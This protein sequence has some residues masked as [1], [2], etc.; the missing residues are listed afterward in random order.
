MSSLQMILFLG[1]ALFIALV[2]SYAIRKKPKWY[3]GSDQEN[4]RLRPEDRALIFLFIFF[5]AYV[6]ISLYDNLSFHGLSSSPQPFSHT[7]LK[8]ED[9][10]EINL[11]KEKKLDYISDKAKPIEVKKTFYRGER[12][13][14]NNNLDY[15]SLDPSDIDD[16]L[17]SIPGFSSVKPK[18]LS[19]VDILKRY[20]AD[21]KSNTIVPKG[22]LL[23]GQ[24]GNGAEELALAIGKEW[25][26]KVLVFDAVD[27]NGFD[28]GRLRIS[29]LFSTSTRYSPVVIIIKNIDY[30]L[31]AGHFAD[32]L[33]LQPKERM[34][35]WFD[36]IYQS[37]QPA[38]IIGITS[39]IYKM[40]PQAFSPNC[41]ASTVHVDY[42]DLN[43]R[44]ELLKSL[45]RKNDI[46]RVDIADYAKK[47]NYFSREYLAAM[48]NESK[49]IANNNQNKSVSSQ[50]FSQAYEKIAILNE[51]SKEKAKLAASQGDFYI[52]PPDEIQVSFDDISGNDKAKSELK[53]IIDSLQNPEKY[54]KSGEVTSRG[55]LLYGPPG[56]GKT[57]MARAL[58]GEARINFINVSGSEFIS[59]WVGEGAS[60][61]RKLFDLARSHKP[62]IIFIDEFDALA[63]KRLEDSSASSRE[64]SHIVNQLLSELD[65]LDKERNKGVFLIAATNRINTIDE[66]LLRPGRIGIKIE[67]KLPNDVERQNFVEHLLK[68]KK[69]SLGINIQE[70][71]KLTKGFSQAELEALFNQANT[72]VQKQKRKKIEKSDLMGFVDEINNQMIALSKLNVD[73]ALEIYRPSQIKAN[74]QSI[75]GLEDVKKELSQMSIYLQDPKKIENIGVKI[76][77]GWIFYGP[78]GTGKTSLARAVAGES[79]VTF[80]STTGSAFVEQWVG[81]G[82]QRVRELFEVA[83]QYRPCILFIDEIDALAMKRQSEGG[84]SQE[85][86]QT[87]NEFL[88]ELDNIDP[89]RNAGIVVIGATNR[90][91]NMDEAVLRPGRLGKK[92]YIRLPNLNEREQLISMF[93][94]KVKIPNSV[95]A[96]KLS[97]ATMGFSGADLEDLIN[98][99]ALQVLEKSGSKITMQDIEQTKEN[100]LFGR[101]VVSARVQPEER[102]RTAYHEAGHA[103]VGI[104]AK[105]YP[106]KFYKIT[107]SMRDETL[108]M[109][110]FYEEDEQYSMT[111]ESLIDIITTKLAGKIAEEIVYGKDTVTSGPA[112]DLKD[113]T[114]IARNMVMEY[115]MGDKGSYIAY[116]YLKTIPEQEVNQ[117]VQTL[118]NDAAIKA[119]EILEQ[120]RDKLDNLAKALLKEEVLD[121]DQVIKIVK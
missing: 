2:V 67:M 17:K 42:P 32:L 11:N 65:N 60:R 115:G 116:E 118:L 94:N 100:I 106:Y 69:Y 33:I 113:A 108:G 75:V 56:T 21:L 19:L 50:D 95:D 46:K 110:H 35:K 68:D 38:L 80:I 103:L 16:D 66:A 55:I 73:L 117:Q 64:E 26:Q 43:E 12:L 109:T 92:V 119:R 15:D 104:Y 53:R 25:G 41:F 54:A 40:D 72:L 20:N 13:T 78:P 70:V 77:K 99:T 85:F 107:L 34:Y 102:E 112:G 120:H 52:I 87:V 48:V 51:E 1:A 86:A 101:R 10:F 47:T 45:F 83:R 28:I 29:D 59:R 36:D 62:C 98:E 37:N 3:F 30:I 74:F 31:P 18:L 76:P 5:P 91:D 71:V 90:I 82:A 14:S 8:K 114:L 105:H 58:A 61:I 121:Y 88:A 93:L 81:L 9:G 7:A 39:D 97:G 23:T 57:S 89:T 6:A 24:T 27:V 111:R 63:L 79:G 49:V 84:G 96:K 44:N 22:L 4:G